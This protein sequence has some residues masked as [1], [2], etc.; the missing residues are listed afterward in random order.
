[1]NRIR[2]VLADD[3]AILREGLRTLIDYQRDLRVVGE[4]GTGQEALERVRE[5]QPRVLCLDISMPGWCAVYTIEQVCAASPA[6][7][8]LVL[9]M[10]DDPAYFRS[11][12]AA[13]ALGYHLKTAPVDGLLGAIRNVAAGN[14]TVDP[15][16]QN[17][18][19]EPPADH[20]SRGYSQLSRREREVL[21]LLVRGHTHQEMADKMFLSIKTIE[22]YHGRI[23]EKTGLKTRA[24]FVRFGLEAGLL[25][26]AEANELKLKNE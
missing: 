6:T 8:I 25:Q 13:G 2:I 4:A 22:T 3:H 24:D 17:A 1:V 10:H 26:S 18:L 21:D 19:N 15:S 16:L 5:T 7:R 11:A 9:T 12:F 20:P 23:R 14:R